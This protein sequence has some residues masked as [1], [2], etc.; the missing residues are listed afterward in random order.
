M[1]HHL[2]S[3]LR[4]SKIVILQKKISSELSDLTEK[5][6]SCFPEKNYFLYFIEKVEK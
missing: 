5:M 6:I 3:K 2:D 4:P 1:N